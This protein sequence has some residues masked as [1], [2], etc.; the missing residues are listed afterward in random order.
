MKAENYVVRGIN[1]KMNYYI[2]KYQIIDL[3]NN[4]PIQSVSNL[5]YN[6]ADKII[7]SPYQNS[8]K[9]YKDGSKSLCVD[10]PHILNIASSRMQIQLWKSF[11]D[12]EEPIQN[13]FA[14]LGLKSFTKVLDGLS[15]FHYL[16]DDEK[17][18]TLVHQDYMM[19]FNQK[20]LSDE[21]RTIPLLILNHDNDGH[22]AL[23]LAI[24]FKRPRCLELM[25]EMISTF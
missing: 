19:K 9:V 22:T 10:C 18:M 6:R 12:S 3:Y 11:I 8:I 5:L 13:K 1:Q 4:V 7:K 17:F 23:D 25:L 24:K 21:E 16:A 2:G 14:A 20:I 15:L